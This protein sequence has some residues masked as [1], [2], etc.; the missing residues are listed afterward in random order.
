MVKLTR[1]YTRGGD[2]GQTSLGDGARVP[3]QS[4]RVEAYGTVD[5]AN[6][7]IGLARLHA[8]AEADAM[9]SR[10]QN[11][12]FDLGADLCTPQGGKRGAARA[13]CASSPPR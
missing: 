10:I 7:A 11:D 6:A 2:K 12:L 9:L 3:K 13:R 5:E 1:I 8:N 4:L